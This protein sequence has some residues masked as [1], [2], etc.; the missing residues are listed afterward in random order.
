MASLKVGEGKGRGGAPAAGRGEGAAKPGEARWPLRPACTLSVIYLAVAAVPLGAG[1]V[2][3]FRG[4]LLAAHAA[5]LVAVVGSER[6]RHSGAAGQWTRAFADLHFLLFLPALYAELPL[7]MEGLPG[8]VTYQD[9]AIQRL[10][11]ALFGSQPAWELAGAVPLSWLSEVLHL[12]YLLYYPIIYAPPLLLYV[13]ARR[14]GS[15]WAH[16]AVQQTMFGIALSMILCYVVFVTWPVQ[17][18]RY[19][20][21]PEGVPGGPFRWMALKVLESGSSRGAAFPS[22][23]VAVAVTQALLAL[24]LQRYLGILLVPVVLALSVGAVYGGFH[25]AVDVLS[26]AVVGLLAAAAAMRLSRA[27]GARGAGFTPGVRDV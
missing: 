27:S 12:G 16:D 21:T 10:E 6:R 11:S 20:G 7:L 23:H 5:A 1:G 9:P 8:E 3:G 18:P 24:R 2:G 13:R 25:Y 14:T 22:S 17:G 4:L 19:L 26:G 15:Q